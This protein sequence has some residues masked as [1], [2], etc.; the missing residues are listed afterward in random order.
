[1]A[2]F[3]GQ[4]TGASQ[5][6][7][8]EAKGRALVNGQEL[9]NMSNLTRTSGVTYKFNEPN[10]NSTFGDSFKPVFGGCAPGMEGRVS[11][12]MQERFSVAKEIS[13]EIITGQRKTYE[14]SMAPS[15]FKG[16]QSQLQRTQKQKNPFNPKSSG[17]KVLK[18]KL[19]Q[20]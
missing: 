13:E 20:Q 3:Q 15:L 5:T 16:L 11:I 17:L 14:P 9:M 10:G 7:A 1:M 12:K 2:T 6:S 4:E 8:G 19:L 18:A